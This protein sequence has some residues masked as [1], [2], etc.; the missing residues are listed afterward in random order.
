MT[1]PSSSFLEVS[2]SEDGMKLLRFL[3]R[4]LAEQAPGAV[5]HRWIRTGQVRVNSG[6][7]KPFSRLAAGDRV[8]I[9]PFAQARALDSHDG[10]PDGAKDRS[11]TPV[12]PLSPTPEM[13]S[14][15][16]LEL[17]SDVSVVARTPQVL[18]LAKPAGLACQPGSGHTDS[19][20]DRLVKAFAGA[21]FIPAP[22]H[23]ID[24]RTSGLVIAGLTHTAQQRLHVLFAS[25]GIHK[26][27]LAWVWGDC[28]WTGPCL[29][30]D[31]LVKRVSAG[32]EGMIALP[33]GRLVPLPD[34]GLFEGG[35][36]SC[37]AHSNVPGFAASAALAVQTFFVD[38]PPRTRAPGGSGCAAVPGE[39]FSATLLLLR[40]FTG[41][42]H[43]LRVQLASRGFP[44]IG[45]ERY[46]SRHFSHMLLHAF[47][48]SLPGDLPSFPD[49][50]RSAPGPVQDAPA[51]PGRLE[52]LLPPPWREPFLPDPALLAAA[53]ERLAEAVV[54]LC[55]L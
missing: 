22:A 29:L 45:D 54:G 21:P 35:A 38:N 10:S 9:P 17:G 20:S 30:K 55:P 27:Y 43:Q 14:G 24:R 26:E 46:S 52:F 44:I 23:R 34:G 53:R 13:L 5:L 3:E 49:E 32:R 12:C 28:P 42:T 48:L 37:D 6:R 15:R 33:G 1:A 31:R 16:S 8:R 2:A 41:R 51:G 39:A 19:L 47:A 50:V 11:F 40:L 7:T 4:R 36:L 25:G 18:V